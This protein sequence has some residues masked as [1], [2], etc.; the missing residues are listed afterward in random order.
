VAVVEGG[1]LGC[2]VCVVSLFFLFLLFAVL[3][4]CP[5]PDPPVFACFFP[6][7]SAPQQGEGRPHD[8]FVAGRSQTVTLSSPL[9]FLTDRF[10]SSRD[11]CIDR[12]KS[13]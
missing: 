3:L 9:S 2:A 4:N 11:R 1:S 5:Y 8:P 13:L 10:T 6:F 7:S 12:G